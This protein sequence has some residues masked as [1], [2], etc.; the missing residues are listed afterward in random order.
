M[1][2]HLGWETQE[3]RSATQKALIRLYDIN[4]QS[5][6]GNLT[7]GLLQSNDSTYLAEG[8]EVLSRVADPNALP[9]LLTL[10]KKPYPEV[11]KH[12]T[13]SVYRTQAPANP[14][15]AEELQ[16]LVTSE[17]EP[18]SVRIN[19]ARA[20]GQMGYDSPQLSIWQTLLTVAKLRGE[21]YTML[22]FFAIRA[23][24]QLRTTKEAVLDTLVRIAAGERD[25]E[26]QKEALAAV[27]RLSVADAEA[28]E[29]LAGLFRQ[30]DALELRL[31]VLEA[32]ADMGSSRV[33]ELASP[34][35]DTEVPVGMRRRAVYALSQVGGREELDLIID[36]AADPALHGYIEGVLEDANGSLIRPLVTRRLK[37]ESDEEVAA[38]LQ[39]LESRL[40]NPY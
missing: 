37:T 21:K 6:V 23:L 7:R 12:A 26:L 16:G 34:L 31:A 17:T 1:L 13:W 14:R 4:P 18:L 33:S 24:G 38:L 35:L 5:V 15:I 30:A 28:E 9:A 20:L 19:A 29:T 39:S 27:R 36:A 2:P 22:R 25:G 40:E 32:L 8:T 11:K 3:V 10:M